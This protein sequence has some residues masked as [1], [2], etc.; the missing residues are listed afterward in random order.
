M[1]HD[2]LACAAACTPLSV[3]AALDQDTLRRF[4]KL[5]V[6][7]PPAKWMASSNSASIE[8]APSLLLRERGGAVAGACG[9][10]SWKLVQS[11]LA[12][13]ACHPASQHLYN[14]PNT[15]LELER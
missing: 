5:S 8:F 4:P 12:Q 3:R 6:L 7:M 9:C 14:V 15:E 13:V 10:C 1:R 2:Y 11:V